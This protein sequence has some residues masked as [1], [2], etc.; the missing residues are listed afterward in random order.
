MR[1]VLDP[2]VPLHIDLVGGCRLHFEVHDGD[3]FTGA[4]DCAP[5]DGTIHP[6]APELCDGIVNACGGSLSA[7]EIDDDSDGY[8]E[9]EVDSNGWDGVSITG[10]DDCDGKRTV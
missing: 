10:G 6:G 2:A 3:G 7:N 9:C 5:D 1:Y 4:D 8:V